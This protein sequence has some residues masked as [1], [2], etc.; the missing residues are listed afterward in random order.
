LLLQLFLL[1]LWQ[2][3]LR[4]TAAAIITVAAATA[5]AGSGSVRFGDVGLE[6]WDGPLVAATVFAA[7]VAASTSQHCCCN[8]YC[9]CSC[10]CAAIAVAAAVV[11]A[12]AAH[13][14]P[15]LLHAIAPPSRLSRFA[16]LLPVMLLPLLVWITFKL[17][18]LPLAASASSNL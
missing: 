18:E 17:Q 16:T 8:Y 4:N 9:Y 14:S 5:A 3:P 6:R 7:A 2:L 11:A 13:A 10:C 1:L 12:A 15:L